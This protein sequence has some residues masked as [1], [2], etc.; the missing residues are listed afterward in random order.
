M[1]LK[2]SGFGKIN[3][4]MEDFIEKL[5]KKIDEQESLSLKNVRQWRKIKMKDAELTSIG[6]VIAFGIVKEI[7]K[8]IS[9]E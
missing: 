3:H 8:K 7:I 1:F 2:D 5:N 4:I 9:K 6:E